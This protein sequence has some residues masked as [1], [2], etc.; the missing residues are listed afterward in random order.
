MVAPW[1]VGG[2]QGHARNPW[3]CSAFQQ[4]LRLCLD[5][6]CCEKWLR[7]VIWLVLLYEYG[8]GS[9]DTVGGNGERCPGMIRQF[10]YFLGVVLCVLS[11]LAE[12]RTR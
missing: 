7:C 3:A 10:G 6:M 9:I 12:S 4:R 5:A 2:M 8:M 1:V 11:I